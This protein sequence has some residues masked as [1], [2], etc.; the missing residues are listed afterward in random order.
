MERHT[1]CAFVIFTIVIR[2]CQQREAAAYFRKEKKIEV[3]NQIMVNEHVSVFH[4]CR[5]MGTTEMKMKGEGR[6][7]TVSKDR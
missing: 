4:C 7:E 1:D 5:C 2:S 3:H 6:K